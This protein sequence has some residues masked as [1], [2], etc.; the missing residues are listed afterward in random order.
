MKYLPIKNKYPG[1][2]DGQYIGLKGLH[3]LAA[4]ITRQ[5][6]QDKIL[7]LLGR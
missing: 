4:T 6:V 3:V 2:N 1:S 5:P 7:V